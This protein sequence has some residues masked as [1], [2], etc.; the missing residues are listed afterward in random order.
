MA[1]PILW[2]HTLGCSENVETTITL[3]DE[4]VDLT[5]ATSRLEFV[6][7]TGAVIYGV[8]GTV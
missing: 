5:G 4:S 3:T 2:E 7:K 8:A 6:S 1:T